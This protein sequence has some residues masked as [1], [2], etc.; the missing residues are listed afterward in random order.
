MTLSEQGS[1]HA[2]AG[3]ETSAA[4]RLAYE[5][6]I[7]RLRDRV[8]RLVPPDARILVVSRGDDALLQL[9]T[10]NATHFPQ[11]DDGRYAGSIP[12]IA[13]RPSAT[14]R[15]C[16]REGPGSSCSLKRPCGGSIITGTCTI[17]CVGIIGNSTGTGT[18]LCSSSS[19]RRSRRQRS[20]W[21]PAIRIRPGARSATYLTPS[22][23]ATWG[24]SSYR[25]G[26]RQR[27]SSP[28][29]PPSSGLYRRRETGRRHRSA[30]HLRSA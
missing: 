11:A 14:W 17:T 2:I 27:L 29:D 18:S 15:P 28:T 16:R 7:V 8:P 25:I 26:R 9:G 30:D 21:P 6:L 4:K 12:S 3:P 20:I 13:P 23:R 19:I 5:A 24:S 1:S 22:C 10:T